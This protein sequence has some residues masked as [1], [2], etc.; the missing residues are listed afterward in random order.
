M[1]ILLGW[2]HTS[3]GNTG[4]VGI[5]CIRASSKT[6]THIVPFYI[7]LPSHLPDTGSI[8]SSG[9]RHMLL[10]LLPKQLSPDSCMAEAS[11]NDLRYFTLSCTCHPPAGHALKSPCSCSPY[12]GLIKTRDDVYFLGYCPSP[13][14]RPL[15]PLTL[16]TWSVLS[17]V[18]PGWPAVSGTKLILSKNAVGDLP[19]PADQSAPRGPRRSL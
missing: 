11:Y 9:L 10:P 13:L 14:P 6:E 15:P 1:Q 8:R 3:S 17:T 4:D 18:T 12:R 7:R 2:S 5:Y 19:N 16:D